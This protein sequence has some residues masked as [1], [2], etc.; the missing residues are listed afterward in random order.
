MTTLLGLAAG[1][2]LILF[3]LRFL[4]KGVDRLL[5]ERIGQ[6]L[7]RI[8]RS[9]AGGFLFGLCSACLAPSSTGLAAVAARLARE[10]RSAVRGTFGILL[11]A[12]VGITA[13]VLAGAGGAGEA[14]PAFLI[15]GVVLFLRT[16]HELGRG[17]GQLLI[18][19]ALVFVGLEVITRHAAGLRGDESRILMGVAA[20]HPIV[21]AIAAGMLT[22]LLQ[23]STATILLLV[24]L[25]A[26]AGAGIAEGAVLPAVAG[27]NAGI[28]FN[29]LVIGW[30]HPGSRQAALANAVIKGVLAVF[31]VVLAPL[32]PAPPGEAA[33]V[34]AIVHLQFN[35]ATA[36]IGLVISGPLIATLRRW[37]GRSRDGRLETRYLS[38]AAADG[39]VRVALAGSAREILR[40][41]DAVRTMMG[42]LQLAW[43]RGDRA[44]A[45]AAIAADDLI[46]ALDAAIRDHL[47]DHGA[48]GGGEVQAECR[49]QL[50][51]VS[52]LESAGDLVEQ[53]LADIVAKAIARRDGLGEDGCRAVAEAFAACERILILA[54][55]VFAT[56][57]GNLVARL[58][59]ESARTVSLVRELRDSDPARRRAGMPHAANAVLGDL[60]LGVQRMVLAVAVVAMDNEE[61]PSGAVG[62][63][64]AR[65]G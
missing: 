15:L 27:A 43:R 63:E 28:A 38:L 42:Q 7:P 56:R 32:L 37:P 58:R 40:V 8:S 23:S 55:A 41:A 1:V 4:R 52:A 18:S 14:W 20:N 33:W 46:D 62:Y 47:A 25:A 19:L 24:G 49:R 13:L 48:E 35:L 11:G 17:I 54:E 50:R 51:Y 5:E 36:A 59:D 29:A 65:T 39:D 12:N 9:Q 2:A 16:R 60:A 45:K 61:A 34:A 30:D 10:P 3:A 53:Q 26:G 6:W 22:T 57:D 31:L 44:L 21:L 64:S